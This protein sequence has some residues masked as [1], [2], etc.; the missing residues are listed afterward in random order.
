MLT[1]MMWNNTSS[2]GWEYLVVKR[3]LEFES[4]VYHFCVILIV[5]YFNNKRFNMVSDNTI[6]DL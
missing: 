1:F 5:Y 3:A 6:L 4:S 2:N